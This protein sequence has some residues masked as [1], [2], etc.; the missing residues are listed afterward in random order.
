MC[1]RCVADGGSEG[2]AECDEDEGQDDALVRNDGW[3]GGAGGRRVPEVAET[4]DGREE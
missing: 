2:L 3:D 4:G 1:E